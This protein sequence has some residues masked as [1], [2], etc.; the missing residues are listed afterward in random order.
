MWQTT[1]RFRPDFKTAKTCVNVSLTLKLCTWEGRKK[2]ISCLDSNR[3]P[4]K[5][6]VCETEIRPSLSNDVADLRRHLNW[7]N[8][9]E[10]QLSKLVK[11]TKRR[12]RRRHWMNSE[13]GR[14]KYSPWCSDSNSVWRRTGGIRKKK[15][16][17]MRWK[18]ENRNRTWTICQVRV[19]EYLIFPKEEGQEDKVWRC[20]R[21]C[22]KTIVMWWTH[23]QNRFTW[24]DLERK[25][26]GEKAIQSWKCERTQRRKLTIWR[27]TMMRRKTMGRLGGSADEEDER[28]ARCG[29]PEEGCRSEKGSPDAVARSKWSEWS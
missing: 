15:Q 28:D 2:K 7:C 23:T 8:Y 16:L 9:G 4:I 20:C 5:G 29:L 1:G 17:K 25:P 6:C 21:C 22:R 11:A 24:M 26:P 18:Y 3:Q 10:C 12:R 14:E 13:N 27:K 19:R